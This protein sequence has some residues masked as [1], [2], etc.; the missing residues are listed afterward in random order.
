M[1]AGGGSPQTSCPDQQRRYPKPQRRPTHDVVP[2]L[3]HHVEAQHLGSERDSGRQ[4]RNA[5]HVRDV[6]R[7]ERKHCSE[8]GLYESGTVHRAERGK[9]NGQQHQAAS[10]R[11]RQVD[12]HLGTS[13]LQ[14]DAVANNV[15]EPD[16]QDAAGALGRDHLKRE[17]NQALNDAFDRQTESKKN[18]D[19]EGR[20]S[21]LAPMQLQESPDGPDVEHQRE[22]SEHVDGDQMSRETQESRAHKQGACEL[23]EFGHGLLA[24]RDTR[25]ERPHC[26]PYYGRE[27]PQ[28]RAIV[29][30]VEPRLDEPHDRLDRQRHHGCGEDPVRE[31]QLGD[32]MECAVKHRLTSCLDDA[33]SEGWLWTGDE[34][35]VQ[36]LW[37]VVQ[38]FWSILGFAGLI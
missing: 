10:A 11:T 22:R 2:G 25:R 29:D 31:T 30:G 4:C 6:R 12:Q 32:S 35:P 24:P 36:I 14:I 28:A 16:L 15:G 8:R 20:D 3:H 19:P 38:N 34:E 18:G 23:V 27:D 9:S 33:H 21:A 1:R 13:D 37:R 7:R 26:Q 5:Q 17:A